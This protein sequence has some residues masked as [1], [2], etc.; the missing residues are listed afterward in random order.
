MMAIRILMYERLLSQLQSTSAL[1]ALPSLHVTPHERAEQIHRVQLDT[2]SIFD[3]VGQQLCA[4]LDIS[5]KPV[6]FGSIMDN[7]AR[8]YQET[9]HQSLSLQ[10]IAQSLTTQLD[11]WPAILSLR[12]QLLPPQALEALVTVRSLFERATDPQGR[13]QVIFRRP[14]LPADVSPTRHALN[15]ADTVERIEALE[16]EDRQIHTKQP[17]VYQSVVQQQALVDGVRMLMHSPDTLQT[18]PKRNYT[19]NVHW[20]VE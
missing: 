12:A 3:P 11:V 17:H 16:Q 18:F 5:E 19:H 13:N 15:L 14:A 10:A 9:T 6:L 7:L 4:L 2:R 8:V 1:L 20:L